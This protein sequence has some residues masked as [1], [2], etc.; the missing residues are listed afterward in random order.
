MLQIFVVIALIGL[1]IAY[2]MDGYEYVQPYTMNEP[3]LPH[4]YQYEYSVGDI[5]SGS[6]KSSHKTSLD[7]EL[8]RPFILFA[9]VVGFCWNQTSN[10]WLFLLPET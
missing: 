3:D 2:P 4:P 6:N 9:E 7:L 10:S 1:A 5:N 8:E